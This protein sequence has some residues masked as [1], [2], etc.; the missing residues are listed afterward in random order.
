MA[1]ALRANRAA[2]I[3][4]ALF[5]VVMMGVAVVGPANLRLEILLGL[6]TL[7]CTIAALLRRSVI[8]DDD[9]ITVRNL[10]GKRHIAWSAV[11]H[12]IYYWSY[13]RNTWV[14]KPNRR[15]T[16]ERL[17]IVAVS[18]DFVEIDARF[19]LTHLDD[20]FVALHA[21]VKPSFYPFKLTETAL[22][23]GDKTIDLTEIERVDIGGSQL[24]VIKRGSQLAHMSAPMKGMKNPMLFVDA[25]VDRGIVVVPNQRLFIPACVLDKVRAVEER[26]AA[27]PQARVVQTRR[28]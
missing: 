3:G 11:S 28:T 20:V 21:H 5:F 26:R 14:R 27:V 4:F 24:A 17:V 19:E 8:I 23:N 12:Y 1:I 6:L 25:L 22:T 7:G 13:I 2:P 15:V 16:S 10:L 9:G 18:D